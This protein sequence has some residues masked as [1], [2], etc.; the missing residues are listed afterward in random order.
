MIHPRRAELRGRLLLAGGRLADL[1]TADWLDA[2]YVMLTE[3]ADPTVRS[4]L[5]DLFASRSMEEVD[6]RFAA[7]RAESDARAAERAAREAEQ[8]RRG[9]RTGLGRRGRVP[10]GA[11]EAAVAEWS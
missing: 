7:L 5:D 3:H 6:Q 10:E 1:S 8:M 4:L 11:L 2:G 9:R